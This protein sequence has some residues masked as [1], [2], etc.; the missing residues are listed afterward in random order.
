MGDRRPSTSR[1]AGRATSAP[2]SG[3]ELLDLDDIALGDLVLLAAGLDDG[4]HRGPLLDTVLTLVSCAHAAHTTNWPTVGGPS[5]RLRHRPARRGKTPG[6]GS[7]PSPRRPP[8]GRPGGSP[9]AAAPPGG[10]RRLG[11]R[12][13]SRRVGR[14]RGQPSRRGRF[15]R[16]YGSS[17]PSR[18]WGSRRRGL[19]GGLGLLGLGS[20]RPGH[21]AAWLLGGRALGA[22]Q[23][24]SVDFSAPSLRA[25]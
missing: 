16:G 5:F 15:G 11:G 22:R 9:P 25:A 1:I 20:Q 13:R 8:A 7:L 18:P 10:L 19:L 2:G 24:C 4:V 14:P 17:A 21:S 12:A 6:G 23:L 3:V